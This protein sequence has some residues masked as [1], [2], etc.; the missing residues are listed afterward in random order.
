MRQW[1]LPVFIAAIISVSASAQ[2]DER[3]L[4]SIFEQQIE[5]ADVWSFA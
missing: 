1:A 2:V 4:G 5:T 3:K